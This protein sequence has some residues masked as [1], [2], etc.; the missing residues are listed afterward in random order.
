MT[1]LMYF[2]IAVTLML[3][4]LPLLLIAIGLPKLKQ[5][6]DEQTCPRDFKQGLND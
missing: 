5:Q 3:I 1:W 6:L 2:L 4:A